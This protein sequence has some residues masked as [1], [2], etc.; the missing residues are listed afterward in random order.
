MAVTSRRQLKEAMA[1]LDER[2]RDILSQRW[3]NEEK[4]T[5]H[6][7][8]TKYGISA[9]RARQIEKSAMKKIRQRMAAKGL[10]SLFS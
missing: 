1:E 2:S 8:A 7:M 9:E 4:V 3:L 6:D 5:L 10:D